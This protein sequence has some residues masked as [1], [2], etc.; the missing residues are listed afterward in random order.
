MIVTLVQREYRVIR[1]VA[2]LQKSPLGSNYW[3]AVE[4]SGAPVS[5]SCGRTGSVYR[6]QFQGQFYLVLTLTATLGGWRGVIRKIA[7]PATSTLCG[8]TTFYC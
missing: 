5:V 3:L 8:N 4:Q 1:M 2:W 7:R 6:V